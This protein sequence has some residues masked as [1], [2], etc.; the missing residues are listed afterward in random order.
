A[1]L[2]YDRVMIYQL[3]ADGAGKVVAES[4]RSDLESFMGQYFPASDIPQQARALYLRNPIRVISDVQF[5]TVAINPVLDP[6]GEPLDLSYAHLR[7]VSPIH[8]EYLCNMGVG[9]S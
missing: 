9:A 4:K 7:S 1:V 2:G 8:C 5:N 6:S 3:G